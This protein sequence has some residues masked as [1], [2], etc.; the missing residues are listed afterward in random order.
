MITR[1]GSILHKWFPNE[2]EALSAFYQKKLALHTP[3]LVR[4]NVF[5]FHIEIKNS[6]LISLNKEI[7]L[8]GMPIV[9]HKIFQQN[10]KTAKYY[11]IT[12]IGILIA[13]SSK[14]LDEQVYEITDLFLETTP[15]RL[16]F[17]VNYKNLLKTRKNYVDY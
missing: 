8:N 14:L 17:S 13:K 6:K 1:N 5:N 12:N 4:Y 15:G 9:L 2:F 7:F 11:L 16:I 10:K 3:I